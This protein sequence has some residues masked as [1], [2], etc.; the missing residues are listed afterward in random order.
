MIERFPEGTPE[1]PY[2]HTIIHWKDGAASL[3]LRVE[4]GGMLSSP[5]APKLEGWTAYFVGHHGTHTVYTYRPTPPPTRPQHRRNVRRYANLVY[6]IGTIIEDRESLNEQQ[7]DRLWAY[8]GNHTDT[9]YELVGPVVDE[10]ED[11]ILRETTVA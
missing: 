2:P 6:N 3:S 4:P 10:I 9:V 5:P 11:A 8:L 7:L 1:I